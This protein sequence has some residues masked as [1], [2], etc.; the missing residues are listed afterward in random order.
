MHVMTCGTHTLK[1]ALNLY[2]FSSGVC[3]LVID[4]GQCD[5]DQTHYYFDSTTGY[6][7]YGGCGGNGNRFETQADCVK[8]CN[9]DCKLLVIS[10]SYSGSA[11]NTASS[12]FT[13]SFDLLSGPACEMDGKFY[14]F[15]A[16][17]QSDD[18]CNTW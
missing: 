16:S 13:F 1:S 12:P 14:P 5:D 17:V 10:Q 6:C 9:P 18:G 11:W 7:K 4:S 2:L 3:L 15:E 8:A